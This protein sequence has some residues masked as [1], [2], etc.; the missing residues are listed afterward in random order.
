MSIYYIDN[1][2]SHYGVKG[3]KWGVRHD[4][5]WSNGRRQYRESVKSAKER[6]K[7]RDSSI[8]KRYDAFEKA[9]EQPYKKGQLLSDK[10]V[11]RLNK[12]D[13]QARKDWKSSKEQYKKDKRT[14]KSEYKKFKSSKISEYKD[15][16]KTYEGSIR[17]GRCIL[18]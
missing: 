13:E 5:E 9:I 11:A 3:M 12:I 18:Q 17:Q 15:L 10:D 7:N 4:N 8:A 14:A 16:K 2:L 1:E 6:R